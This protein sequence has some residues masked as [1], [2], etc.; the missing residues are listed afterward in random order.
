MRTYI[1]PFCAL[2][3]GLFPSHSSAEDANPEPGL[4]PVPR[5][6]PLI[7]GAGRW[8]SLERRRVPAAA[9]QKS[10]ERT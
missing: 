6:T 5:I 8:P 3:V 2:I 1:I 10:G 9:T 7:P 4:P